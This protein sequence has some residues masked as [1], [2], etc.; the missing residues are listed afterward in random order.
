MERKRNKL[1]VIKDI[2][3]VIREKNGKIKP[4]HILYKSNLS[5]Q[6]MKEYLGELMKKGFVEETIL[7]ENKTYSVTD[8]G[9]NYLDEYHTIM[10]FTNSFGLD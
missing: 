9:I 7:K 2:L 4:T 5:H 3:T 8:K 6:M 10:E 1:E